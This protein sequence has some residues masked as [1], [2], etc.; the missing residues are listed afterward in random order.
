MSAV[1]D[2]GTE[3]QFAESW[4]WE[5]LS[6]SLIV[7]RCASPNVFAPHIIPAVEPVLWQEILELRSHLGTLAAE[8]SLSVHQQVEGCAFVLRLEL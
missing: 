5:G 2:R 8:A 7:R 4:E 1:Q 6:G 3:G